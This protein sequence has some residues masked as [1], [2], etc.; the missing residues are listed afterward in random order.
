[1]TDELDDRLHRIG[2]HH[3][4]AKFRLRGR[5]RAVVDLRGIATV[6]KHAADL[7]TR[8]L[9]PAEPS[10]DGRQTPYRGHPV[11][12]A[13]HATATCC[14]T[15]LARWHDIPAGHPLSD[16]ERA[17]VVEAICRWI[18]KQYAPSQPPP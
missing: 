2:Q 10:N 6:R 5:D 14:R 7:I 12:V 8:R 13:Q 3:F 9:A 15:C 16:A 11:F 17:Y 18:E 1:M 4:R